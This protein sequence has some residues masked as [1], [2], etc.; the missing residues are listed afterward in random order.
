MSIKV[1]VSVILFIILSAHAS[2]G[3]GYYYSR[4]ATY[5]ETTVVAPSM[6]A[7][8]PVNREDV[9]AIGM[10]KTQVANGRTFNAMMYNPALLAKKK[11]SMEAFS[12]MASL[13]PQTYKAASFLKDNMNEF[14]EATSLKDVW[15]GVKEFQNA[16]TLEDQLNA[17]RKIQNGLKFP[18]ELLDKVVGTSSNPTTHGLKLLPAI[19]MQAGNL[20]VSLYGVAQSGFEMHQS[21]TVDALLDV[22]I[23]EDLSNPD[24]VAEAVNSLWLTLQSV[25]NENNVDDAALPVAYSYSYMDIVGAVGY[26]MEVARGLNVGMNLKIVHRRL[27]VKRIIADS[28][29]K[30]L[31]E[32]LKDMQ[33]YITGFTFDLGAMYRFPFG[34]QV[35]LSMENI[36]PFRKI[37]STLEFPVVA[38]YEEYDRDEFGNKI[39][40]GQDTALV[41]VSRDVNV[42]FP[43]DLRIPFIMNLGITHPV[44][45]NWDVSVDIADMAEQ[46]TLYEKY[47]ERFRAGTEY[48]WNAMNNLGIAT[49]VGMADE[50]LT[51]GLGLNLFRVLQI[52]A[53]YAY[54]N[55]VAD[56]TYYLQLRLGW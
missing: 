16:A 11:Y 38:T 10:G 5:P 52:D 27:S 2:F 44:T 41:F 35:G 19:T 54:D 55:Y 7:F 51:L 30:I 37:T 48:R 18:H 3:Q 24:Q 39:V 29:D 4:T 45:S 32:A 21:P 56:N 8:I 17:I 6:Q 46:N 26:G 33:Y 50:H 47:F 9:K 1:T 31:R 28:F 34:T 40:S 12:F 53:A 20:G 36:I 49:R 23:P 43:F 15:A 13:P 42:K 25:M 22:Y 14:T